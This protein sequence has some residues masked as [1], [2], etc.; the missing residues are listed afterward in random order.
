MMRLKSLLR[1]L[2]RDEEGVATF[3][4][5]FLFPV[6]FILFLASFETAMVMTRQ[7]LLDR[8]MDMAVRVVRLNTTN[9]PNYDQLKTM[10]CQGSGLI[11]NCED[12]LKLEMWRQDPRGTMTFDSV[13]DCMDRSLTVQPASVYSVG[14]QND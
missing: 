9:P 14:Q 3:E 12:S 6:Y 7:V 11:A 1:R 10:I 5:L 13:P 2:R 8:G 4:F